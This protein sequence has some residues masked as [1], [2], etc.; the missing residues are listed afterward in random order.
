MP[1]FPEQV[2]LPASWEHNTLGKCPKGPERNLGEPK[3]KKEEDVDSSHV[4]NIIG[5]QR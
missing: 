1:G 3:T 4:G 2:V 5:C